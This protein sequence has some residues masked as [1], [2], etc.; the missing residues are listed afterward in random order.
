LE[1]PRRGP[2]GDAKKGGYFLRR[3]PKEGGFK[4]GRRLNSLG[5]GKNFKGN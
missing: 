2:F 5:L 1:H 3:T 4:K